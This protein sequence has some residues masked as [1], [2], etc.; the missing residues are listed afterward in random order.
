MRGLSERWQTLKWKS[1]R[2]EVFLEG[3]TAN[4][5]LKI[6]VLDCLFY[7]KVSWGKGVR[8]LRGVYRQCFGSALV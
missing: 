2:S 7:S 8:N 4:A 1:R 3:K 5:F 6:V